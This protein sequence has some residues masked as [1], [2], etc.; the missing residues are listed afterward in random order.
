MRGK[1]SFAKHSSLNT[2]DQSHIF[3]D[4]AEFTDDNSLSKALKF[5]AQVLCHLTS[6]PSNLSSLNRCVGLLDG[7]QAS[8]VTSEELDRLTTGRRE[9]NFVA[10]VNLTKMFLKHLRPEFAGH[11][12]NKVFA[13]LFDMN[14]LFE[15]FIYQ[16]LKKNE[17]SL[18]IQVTAQKRK[19]L[20]SEEKDFLNGE[21]WVRRNL[22]DT[23]TDILVKPQN[24]PEL[25]IDT[26]YKIVHSQKSHY[27]ISNQDAYQVLA[28]RQIHK[29]EVSEPSVA[30]LYPK[31]S[32]DIKKEFR[33]NGS[34]STFMAW[35]IDISRDL[36]SDM[37]SLVEELKKLIQKSET[38]TAEDVLR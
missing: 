4:Y 12:K 17:S 23:Y 37:P 24:G 31:S 9:P 33:I 14:E 19:R 29:T 38:N 15:E 34:S 18:S 2:F 6:N 3:C 16:V 21:K 1:I 28:Y 32:E 26:K 35:T 13:I 30:L 22:F 36:K 8:F 5:V 7:V 25:I 10:L 11:K 27:G 20:V